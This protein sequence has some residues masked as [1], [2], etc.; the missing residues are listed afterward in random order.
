MK[1]NAKQIPSAQSIN[2]LRFV[3]LDTLTESQRMAYKELV[4][5]GKEQSPPKKE[6]TL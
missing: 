4:R 1:G 6:E 2:L 3:F 5:Q